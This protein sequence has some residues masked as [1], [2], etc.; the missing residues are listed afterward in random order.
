M[1]NSPKAFQVARTIESTALNTFVPSGITNI[2]QNAGGTTA[3]VTF[4]NP[5]LC[6]EMNGNHIIVF[7][8]GTANIKLYDYTGTQLTA[9]ELPT[10]KCA[11]V[12]Q[13]KGVLYPSIIAS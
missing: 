10:K 4:Y 11:I 3:A 2:I 13:S 6:P 12:I 1:N 9:T 5:A 8:G 7:N